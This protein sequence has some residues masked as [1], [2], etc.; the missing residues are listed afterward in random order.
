M[1][2][3]AVI[4]HMLH[5]LSNYDV[6]SRFG[7]LSKHCYRLSRDNSFW[8][9]RVNAHY[10][11]ITY[12]SLSLLHHDVSSEPSFRRSGQGLATNWLA[13]YKGEYIV[14]SLCLSVLCV[15]LTGPFQGFGQ[16]DVTTI[17]IDI[18]KAYTK[19]MAILHPMKNEVFTIHCYK[20]LKC[21]LRDR[22]R[23]NKKD[24]Y[25]FCVSE[26]EK[27]KIILHCPSSDPQSRI[28]HGRAVQ[29]SGMEVVPFALRD[30]GRDLV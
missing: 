23:D 18:G 5:Y 13:I 9:A 28:R 29:R 3:A 2:R 11:H 1:T 20:V 30:K 16:K 25:C 4:L 17:A 10:P 22:D 12:I 19:R 8:R 21:D 7:R 15:Q 6:L 14:R 26:K 27:K 24:Y